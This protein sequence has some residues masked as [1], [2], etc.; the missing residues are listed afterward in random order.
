VLG[1]VLIVGERINATRRR[2]GEALASRDERLIRREAR[3]QVE[4]GADYVDVNAGRGAGNEPEELAWLAR[5]VED[6]VE[7]PLCLDSA[8]AEALAR[9]LN[10]AKR[11]ALVNSVNGD[12][13]R[14]ARILPLVAGHGASVVALCMEEGGIPETAADRLRVAERLAAAV[15]GAGIESSRVYFDPCVLAASTS[16]GQPAAVLEATREIRRAWPGSHVISG[17]SNVSFGLPLRGL[18]NRTYLAMMMACGADAFIVD[19]TAKG[20]A[21]TLAA[22][23]VLTGRDEYAAGYISAFREGNLA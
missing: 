13:E 8:D 17:L 23:A 18:V 12:P 7:A 15:S 3:R 20:T 6:E 5:T 19:P 9:A 11:P 1:N 16:P 21:A 2:I 4:A 22:A 14:V 10:E